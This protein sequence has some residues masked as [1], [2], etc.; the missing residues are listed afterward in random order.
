MVLVTLRGWC[1]VKE[2]KLHKL[3]EKPI[4]GEW[5]NE[6]DQDELGI[7]VIR[8]TNFSN[9]I[10]FKNGSEMTYRVIEESKIESKKLN[11]G[12]IIIEKSGGSP[13][14]PVGR[15]L[16]YDY[17]DSISRICNN[18]TAILRPTPGN[19]PKYL[20]YLLSFLYKRG[21]VL[22][23]QNK[24]TGIINLKLNHYLKDTSVI[25]PSLETQ[26]K[27]VEV[28]DKAQGLIDA[29]KEQ[30]RLMDELIQSV[31]YEMFGDPVTNPKG[32]EVR[33]VEKVCTNIMGGGT[34]SKNNLDFYVGDIPW[35]TPKDMKID[36][37]SDSMD[38]INEDAINNS[39]AK[40]ISENSVLMVIRS[41]ILK[42]KLPVAINKRCV[43]VNQDMK[44]FIINKNFTNSEFF[45]YFWKSCENY[46]LSKVRA[47]TA[48]NIEF[49]QIKDMQYILPPCELQ[50]EFSE[51]VQQIQT[52][53]TL[54]EMSLCE[55]EN[56]F[57]GLMQ[58]AFAGSLFDDLV[59][60]K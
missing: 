3:F 43:A 38:H 47:V 42:R 45:M 37:I 32:W 17:T 20:A 7:E 25:I 24:T 26:K 6:P 52:N 19:D 8:T 56:N 1:K 33:T 51:K 9:D 57:S 49:K 14:Q 18:F 31:F 11:Y 53:K 22:K 48:D 36:F 50:N 54:L 5:G 28:L 23:H 2:L 44:A 29:R 41:G 15:V 21:V 13:T 59:V 40:L 58:S 39:S 34:P 12:D 55:L 60:G 46:V 16:F 35:V 30:I 27:I 4:S 10:R